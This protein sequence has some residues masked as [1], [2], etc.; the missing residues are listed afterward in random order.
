MTERLTSSQIQAR[1]EGDIARHPGCR[2][3]RVAVKVR[4]MEGGLGLGSNWGADFHATG[5]IRD[6]PACQT[7]LVEILESALEDYTLTLDS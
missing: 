7:A 2:G 3:F 5:E 1:L 6:R 4:R